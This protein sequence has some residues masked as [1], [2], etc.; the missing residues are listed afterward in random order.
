MRATERGKRYCIQTVPNISK[1]CLGHRLVLWTHN[2]I[3]IPFVL[4]WGHIRYI[5]LLFMSR[6]NGWALQF[7][8]LP[9]AAMATGKECIASEKCEDTAK[10]E[11]RIAEACEKQQ[12]CDEKGFLG[13][14]V[15][16]CWGGRDVDDVD[17]ITVLER[18]GS[19][20]SANR[21]RKNLET[22][23]FDEV[24]VRM[25][26]WPSIRLDAGHCFHFAAWCFQ[27]LRVV[28]H[29]DIQ[30]EAILQGNYIIQ[31]NAKLSPNIPN[32][33]LWPSEPS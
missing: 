14:L 31:Q 24:P 12:A 9:M 22:L 4:A 16:I 11:Q 28:R 15:W 29:K 2:Q 6:L 1:L 19:G 17:F 25:R 7:Q 33:K 27:W 32:I 18:F 8:P 13:N 10:D 30:N 3:K 20:W 21:V 23:S 26:H 5:Y